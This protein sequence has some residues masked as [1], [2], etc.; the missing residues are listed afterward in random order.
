MIKPTQEQAFA[1]LAARLEHARREH[2]VFATSETEAASVIQGEVYELDLA[3]WEE[4]PDRV[5]YE[6]LDVAATAG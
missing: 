1:M 6:A 2:P 5:I 4:G 3:I